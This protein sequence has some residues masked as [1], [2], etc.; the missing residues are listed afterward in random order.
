[1]SSCAKVT[2][3]RHV[4]K[5]SREKK[6]RS[7]YGLWDN[8]IE[9]KKI[10]PWTS[11]LGIQILSELHFSAFSLFCM[12]SYLTTLRERWKIWSLE[13]S[14]SG[15]REEE[16]IWERE[17]EEEGWKEWREK[18]L[19]TVYIV[20]GKYLFIIKNRNMLEL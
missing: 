6:V 13:N 3:P 5:V 9:G 17:R 7:S 10:Q 11:G 14:Y 2:H 15:E 1:M 12:L 4:P 19:W 20:W 18:K 16:Y 8:E